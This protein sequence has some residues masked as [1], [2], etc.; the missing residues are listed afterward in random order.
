MPTKYY[1]F[2]LFQVLIIFAVQAVANAGLVI[3]QPQLLG[4]TSTAYSTSYS[5]SIVAQPQIS[6]PVIQN[7]VPQYSLEDVTVPSTV[8]YHQLSNRINPIAEQQ[9]EYQ[10]QG[11]ND[12]GTVNRPRVSQGLAGKVL[13]I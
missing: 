3:P 1:Y 2:L 6:A 12:I 4:A 10:E 5:R 7:L 11:Y 8:V 9:V 13:L